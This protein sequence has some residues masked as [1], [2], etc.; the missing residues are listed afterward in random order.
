MEKLLSLI[1]ED[2]DAQWM[3][4]HVVNLY[5]HARKQTFPAYHQEAQYAYDLLKNE[6]F[7]AELLHFPADGKTTYQDKC[8]PIGWDVTTHKLTLLTKVQGIDDPVIADYEKE[9]LHAVKGSVSTPAGGIR[10]K[11]IT[12]AQMRAGTDVR[13]QFVLLGQ[14]NRPLNSCMK[15][16]LDLGA[17]GW[18]S[19][20]LEDPDGTPDSVAWVNAATEY[21]NWHVIAED[22]PF[23]GYQISP[24]VGRR[25]RK[26]CE[27]GVV[28]ICAESDSRRY[29]STLPAVTALLPGEDKREI[30]INAH[31]YEPLIDDNS[32][33]VVAAVAAL[34]CLRKL[35]E[36]RKLKYSVRVVFASEL[37]GFAAA[38]EHFGGNLEDK[39]IGA[40][41]FDGLQGINSTPP[42][43]LMNEG[44][45]FYSHNKPVGFAGNVILHALTDAGNALFSNMKLT[46]GRRE[47]LGDD[48]FLGDS[49]T[50]MPTVWPRYGLGKDG[51]LH[52]NS[53][54]NE[55]TWNMEAFLIHAAVSITWVVAMAMLTEDEV[56]ALLPGAVKHAQAV[57][58]TA[59]ET[60]IRSGED[61]SARMQA[62]LLREQ[63]RIRGMHLWS[64]DDAIDA[65]ADSLQ[66]PALPANLPA[67]PAKEQPYY[68]LQQNQ[69]WY[70]YS[71]N[72]VF[73]RAER[74]Q[75]HDLM[76]V[77]IKQRSSMPGTILYNPIADVLSR[78]DG[79]KTLKTLI[80]EVE[81]D[82]NQVFDDGVVRS[83]L[84]TCLRIAD[85]GYLTV[86]EGMPVTEELVA[87]ALRAVGVKEGDTLL[88]HTGLTNI[89]HLSASTAIAAL[90]SAVGETGN[91]LVPILARPYVA[92]EGTVNTSQIFRPY[93]TRPDGEL[94]DAAI[95]TGGLSRAIVKT[96][97]IRRSGHPTHEWAAWGKNAA[98][99][100][101]GH[102][103]L[104][105]P[106]GE[107]SPLKKALEKNGSVVFIGCD[108]HS[109]T[110]LHYIE[111]VCGA[112]YLEAA[113]IKYIDK[114]GT[115]R[116]TV[117]DR[118]LPGHRNFYD[119]LGD[120]E[121]YSE[122]V[123]RG[124]KIEAAPLGNA[125]V[126]RME[127]QQLF[128]IGAAMF[129]DDPYATLCHDPQCPFCSKYRKASL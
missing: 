36:S 90:K 24:R 9:P 19:D 33:G 92:F 4:E 109:N 7:D 63:G 30:W 83:Y 115:L 89:G 116:T 22:R 114:D 65:A 37:Y 110:F 62:L 25:L 10:A 71:E 11:L 99:L 23:I 20:F 48:C 59:S 12:E 113:I 29:E 106:A 56:L 60:P 50:G 43:I 67:A 2:L 15:M 76:K 97:G 31:L 108:I 87:E 40:I 120:N 82:I 80:R 127:L 124:L 98:E 46:K 58:Q 18:V 95:W 102:G 49:T 112:D 14:I 47:S 111:T 118:N 107:T 41:N 3:N 44:P 86:S 129:R 78:M 28:M 126:Y 117:I 57:L 85:A 79:K 74:G 81:W 125:T 94:R 128:D 100:V 122:M 39:T 105:T 34:K 53:A 104:D 13:G 5:R 61:P 38:A 77:P 32:N 103:F 55:S 70:D 96:P 16:L 64:S 91:F 69:S 121:F 27:D 75:P 21:S 54:Q 35:Q 45:D 68:V 51:S 88:V 1:K 6:G 93:D 84:H 73:A 26:A 66:I 17:V 42:A 123:R 119:G 72:F 52:H 8:M 101:A